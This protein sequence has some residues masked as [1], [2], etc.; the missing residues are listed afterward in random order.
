M[1]TPLLDGSMTNANRRIPLLTCVLLLSS[2]VPASLS[3][4]RGSREPGQDIP[5]CLRDLYGLCPEAGECRMVADDAGISQ[6]SCY[7]SGVRS[8]ATW[9]R[10]G[11]FPACG[12]RYESRV[13]KPDGELCYVY[14]SVETPDGICGE[15]HEG[16][17]K[18]AM[19]QLIASSS[20][21]IGSTTVR[22]ATGG[23]TFHCTFACPTSLTGPAGDCQTGACP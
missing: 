5:R 9:S 6:T 16:T 3:C 4:E 13:F 7:A 2:S 21:G 10:G 14:E 1:K 17:W 15:S 23:E 12:S 20:D 18:D 22:C 8:K 11:V 19:G